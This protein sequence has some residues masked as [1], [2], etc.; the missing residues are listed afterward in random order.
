MSQHDIL[1]VKKEIW[2]LL[3]TTMI[4]GKLIL[5]Y[6]QSLYA[7]LK[8][9]EKQTDKFQIKKIGNLIE[10]RYVKPILFFK[11]RKSGKQHVEVILY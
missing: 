1:Y 4:F 11:S 8:S 9:V 6:D 10:I 3:K 7:Y 2:D 5:E